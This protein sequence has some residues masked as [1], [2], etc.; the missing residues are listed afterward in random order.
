MNLRKD[1]YRVLLWVVVLFECYIAL[2]IVNQCI[3][4]VDL[5]YFI[6]ITLHDGYLGS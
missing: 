6:I 1:H 2:E 3:V 4:V 5:S